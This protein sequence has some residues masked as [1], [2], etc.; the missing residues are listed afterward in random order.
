MLE[1][2]YKIEEIKEAAVSSYKD[3]K[4]NSPHL[5]KNHSDR[6]IDELYAEREYYSPSIKFD[7]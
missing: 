5:E 2:N 4:P 1:V 3:N 7:W 6:S